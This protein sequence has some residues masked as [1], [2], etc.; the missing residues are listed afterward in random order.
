MSTDWVGRGVDPA[1]GDGVVLRQNAR[2]AAPEHLE[3]RRLRGGVIAEDDIFD[4]RP[5]LRL[6]LPEP[7]APSP[8]SMKP[9]P[10]A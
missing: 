2:K 8:A 7:E 9:Q 6:T 10:V 1:L 5:H 3:L 4:R